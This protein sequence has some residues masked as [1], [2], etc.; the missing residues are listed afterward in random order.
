MA[1]QHQAASARRSR[2]RRRRRVPRLAPP[3]AAHPP[4]RGEGGRGV[5][6]GQDRRI[7][8]PLYRTGSGRGGQPRRAGRRTTTSPAPTASTAT[9]SPE[10]YRPRPSWPS[11]S[12]RR[13]A[14]PVA[15]AARCTCSMPTWAFSA[16]TA[17][18][19]GTSPWRPGWRSRPST[20]APIRWRSATSARRRSTTAPSTRPSTWPRSGSCRRSTSARTTAT[21][22]APRWSAPARSTTSPSGPAPTTWRTRWWTGRTCWS[23][24]RPWSARCSA[25]APTSTPPCSRSAPT[26]SWVTRCPTRSTATTAPARRS[27]ISASGTRSRSGPSG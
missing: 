15:R 16:A 27:R 20:G 11:C 18:W 4:L 3:D 6:P 12:A 8:P 26:G 19:A 23:C 25:P 17:S 13:P 21:A 7:L 10:G 2:P 1:D 24:T 5:Q 9:R 14:A 22:W